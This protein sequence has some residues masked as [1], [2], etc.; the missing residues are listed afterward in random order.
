MHKEI[1]QALFDLQTDFRKELLDLRG[2][3]ILSRTYPI[4]EVSFVAPSRKDFVIR[5]ICDD[6]NEKPPSVEL[7]NSKKERL[8]VLPAGDK[9]SVFNSSHPQTGFPFICSPGSR[10]YHS[11]P[12]HTGDVW[13]NYKEQSDFTLGEILTQIHSAWRTSQDA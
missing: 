9:N 12:S 2:W 11:H 8:T 5:M 10:E 7:L 3:V 4:L 6:W 1:S 13:E